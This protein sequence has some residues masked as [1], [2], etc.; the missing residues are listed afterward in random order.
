MT[1]A[2]PRGVADY[3]GG[4]A[5]LRRTLEATLR[6]LSFSWGYAEVIPP[7]FEY[8]DMLVTDIGEQLAEELYRFFDRDGKLLAL[9]PDLTVP[10][11]RI[12]GSKFYDQ[13]LPQRYFYAG[14]VFR[15]EEPRAGRQREFWQAGVELAG[16]SSPETDAEVLSLAATAL[17]D[18]GLENFRFVL[19]HMGYF[20]GLI[21][22]L[23]L[24]NDASAQLQDALDRKSLNDVQSLVD[25]WNL[26][27]NDRIA[28]LGLL[29]LA[30]PQGAGVLAQASSLARNKQMFEAVEH[31]L[32]IEALLD[33]YEVKQFFD[34]DLADV[35]AMHYY[36]GITFKAYTPGIGF[37]VLNGGRYDHLVGEFGHDLPAVGCAFYLDR[38]QLALMRQ[39]GPPADPI[40]DILVYPCACGE[41]I[42]LA[43][44]ARSVGYSVAMALG[45]EDPARFPLRLRCSCAEFVVLEDAGGSR[46]V[47]RKTWLDYL[48]VNPS[49]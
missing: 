19:G 49:C 34:I 12:I 15:Y 27:K 44:E 6:R 18:I 3:F 39:S 38:L 23:A 26:K 5:H 20:H 46:S 47:P 28:V 35:R 31:L 9:R 43:R 11:A 2:I 48:G 24:S 8:A 22:S 13:P 10:T 21:R 41:H 1:P 29:N 25:E 33:Q 32:A 37:S 30:G 40:P 16:V 4:S 17:Q 45:P 7:I 14:P 42:R 36:T